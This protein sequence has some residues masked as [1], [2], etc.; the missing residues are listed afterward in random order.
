MLLKLADESCAG[1][2]KLSK[3]LSDLGGGGGW[4]EIKTDSGGWKGGSSGGINGPGPRGG[5][6]G[7]K[8]GREILLFIGSCLFLNLF[9]WFLIAKSCPG[10]PR[11]C[12]I[13]LLAETFF[14][15]QVR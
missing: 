12:F 5:Y 3:E 15:Q 1:I 6:A 2:W 10:G 4:N 8:G 7:S 13:R 9:N 11:A 14:Q